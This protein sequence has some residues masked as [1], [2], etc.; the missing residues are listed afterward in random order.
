[1]KKMILMLL[2]KTE[3]FLWVFR[4]FISDKIVDIEFRSQ[5]L[6]GISKPKEKEEWI[7]YPFR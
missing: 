4:N 2:R 7:N 5:G 3:S 6:K 1:M